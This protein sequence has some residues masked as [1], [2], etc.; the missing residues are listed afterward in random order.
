[1]TLDAIFEPA[2]PVTVLPP[3]RLS[4]Q[5][6]DHRVANSLQLISSLLA[7]QARQAEEATLRDAL[8]AAVHRIGAVGALHKQLCR[9]DSP[10]AVDIACYLFDLAET[11]ETSFGGSVGH[12]Q[13]SA[14]VQG[15]MVSPNF[16]S[17]L[18]MLI[19]ELVLNACKHAYEPDEPGDIE[20]CLFFPTKSEFR[21]EV[22]DFGGKTGDGEVV[23]TAGLGTSIIDAMCRK[24]NATYNY[25]ADDEGTRFLTNGI[26]V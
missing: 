14:H 11:I 23:R 5:E 13:I 15:R 20:I 12:K 6:I 21:M 25:L 4:H 9:S 18:G 7:V 3:E 2:A 19:T 26:V 1:M 10:R 16:A 22:R 17:V 8:E 24:L